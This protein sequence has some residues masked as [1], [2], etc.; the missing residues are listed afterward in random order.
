MVSPPS[1]ACELADYVHDSRAWQPTRRSTR[2]DGEWKPLCSTYSGALS[3]QSF[4]MNEKMSG[5]H[6]TKQLLCS[7]VLFSQVPP[8]QV[9]GGTCACIWYTCSF[10]FSRKSPHIFLVQSKVFHSGTLMARA[11][12]AIIAKVVGGFN[13]TSFLLFSSL[14]HSTFPRLTHRYSPPRHKAGKNR[15]VALLNSSHYG[16]RLALAARTLMT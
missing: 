4:K 15:L 13:S 9:T 14:L 10:R 5:V 16:P 3:W 7:H 1:L 8:A 11:K 12:M 6:Q 2:E